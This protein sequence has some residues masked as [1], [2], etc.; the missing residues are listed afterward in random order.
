MVVPAEGIL[1]SSRCPSCG[2][3]VSDADAMCPACLGS[4]G[5]K[6]MLPNSRRDRA[7]PL[8]PPSLPPPPGTYRPPPVYPDPAAW[9]RSGFDA[10]GS[11]PE[12]SR[13]G[14]TLIVIAVVVAVMLVAAG[15]FIFVRRSTNSVTYPRVWDPRVA[16]IAGF[17]QTERGLAFKHP[18]YVDFLTAE[19][20]SAAVRGGDDIDEAGQN[21]DAGGGM[22]A[23]D[24]VA[25]FRAVGLVSGAVDLKAAGDTLSDSGT[26]AYYSLRDKRVRVRNTDMTPGLRVTLAHELTHALQDQYFDLTGSRLDDQGTLRPIVEGDAVRVERAY[27]SKVLTDA[28]RDEKAASDAAERAKYEGTL[29]SSNVPSVFSTAFELPYA[30]GPQLVEIAYLQGGNA[31]VD[32]LIRR[33]P[34]TEVS[35]LDPLRA[36]APA[37]LPLAAPLPPGAVALDRSPMGAGFLFL[38]LGEHMEPA[39]A[40]DAAVTWAGE[41]S[42]TSRQ[43]DRICVDSDFRTDANG[44]GALLAGMMAWAA[45]MPE[46]A[47]AT[48]TG[49]ATLV[50]IH[51]CD[52]GADVSFPVPDRTEQTLTYAA[53]RSEI[54]LELVRDTHMTSARSECVADLAART[55]SAADL[56][57]GGYDA[58][59]DPELHTAVARAAVTC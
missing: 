36:E 8:P 35:L 24:V 47:G 41:A 29:A 15:A 30:V 55:I 37:A 9:A 51:A 17:V 7:M 23:D 54:E 33:P 5:V 59:T 21:T 1:V 57:A 6:R 25:Q 4:L 28:E 18:V 56:A 19:Q 44:D 34:A 2:Y 27:A 58:S 49:D 12:S 46:Q 13:V 40:F 48:V 3:T 26:L 42:V 50:H 14:T 22:T 32:A 38:F 31:A 52:P 10:P 11:P 43:Q 20:Y 39:A 16:A 53:V 45:A